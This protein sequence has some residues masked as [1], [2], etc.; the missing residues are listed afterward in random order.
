MR[1]PWLTA[2]SSHPE[3]D[4]AATRIPLHCSASWLLH[5]LFHLPRL[6]LS[7]LPSSWSPCRMPLRLLLHRTSDTLAG[8]PAATCASRSL[9][10]HSCC[11]WSPPR[12]GRHRK[13]ASHAQP[14]RLAGSARSSNTSRRDRV[15]LP[16]YSRQAAAVPDLALRPGTAVPVRQGL[17]RLRRE[18]GTP[19]TQA[20]RRPH[21]QAARLQREGHCLRVVAAQ[22]DTDALA[23]PALPQPSLPVAPD[24]PAPGRGLRRPPAQAPHSPKISCE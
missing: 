5:I 11:C 20:R 24:L 7:P 17:S 10:G 21:A 1:T 14:Q 4:I 2:H 16:D 15:L 9:S 8:G 12:A 23:P 13:A 19:Q 6:L 3:A 22:V 18:V